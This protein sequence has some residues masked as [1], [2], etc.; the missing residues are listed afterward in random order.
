MSK[1]L[2]MKELTDLLK[3]HRA[4]VHRWRNERGLPCKRIGPGSVRYDLEEVKAWME[5]QD[6]LNK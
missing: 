5:S 3:V 2:T 4:T 6:D 1:L